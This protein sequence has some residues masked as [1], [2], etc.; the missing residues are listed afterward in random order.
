[1]LSLLF[2]AYALATTSAA[3]AEERHAPERGEESTKATWEMPGCGQTM[4][5]Y[6]AGV[7]RP[8]QHII[9]GYP[10]LQYELPHQVAL[11][12]YGS[13]VCG[14]SLSDATHVITAA[15]CIFENDP[16]AFS[17]QLGVWDFTKP[18]GREQTIQLSRI[19]NHPSYTNTQNGYDV[20]VLHLQSS[21]RLDETAWP[22]CAPM[23]AKDAYQGMGAWVSGWGATD[24]NGPSYT[25]LLML[26][27]LFVWPYAECQRS[28]GSLTNTMMCAWNQDE[29][30]NVKDACQGDSGGPLAYYDNG[31]WILLG[32]VSW[33]IGCA[34]EYPGV[35]TDVSQVA[36]FLNGEH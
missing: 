32:I 21:A 13:H 36:S 20:S 19:E 29:Q 22:I 15:H 5:E 28:H 14:G 24:V 17:V 34:N 25:P 3:P 31:R 6:D 10:T 23:D 26:V 35:Y 33:G 9:N 4:Y 16:S 7:V 1:M 12:Y 18:S 27:D 8:D 2:L 30:G 11:L